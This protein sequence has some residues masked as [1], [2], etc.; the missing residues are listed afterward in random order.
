MDL[1]RAIRQAA[2][3]YVDAVTEGGN[4][5]ISW[6]A[7]QSFHFDGG[8]VH[9]VS[10][11]GIFKPAVL[12][13]PISIRTT[14]PHADGVRPYEDEIS[15]DGFLRYKYRGTDRNHRDNRLLRNAMDA[16]ATLLYF[17]GVAKGLYDVS[18]AAIVEDQPASLLFNV[19]LFPVDSVA[20]GL[21]IDIEAAQRHH[22]L[23]MVKRRANQQG[24]RQSVLRAYRSQ[25]SVCRLR[26]PELLDAAHIVPDSA[27]GLPIVTNGLSM[28][29]IHHAAFDHGIIGVRPDM[30]AEVRLDV[31][32]EVDG[33]M[34]EHGIQAVHGRTL[35]IPSRG[36]WRPNT[37]ALELRYE[38]FRRAG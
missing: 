11:Q 5:P 34:L 27:G 29:K 19:A 26:H 14:P 24:F 9:L 2:F 20:F 6:Q 30:V 4:Q 35:I 36:S 15:D 25:C 22:Y 8:R 31:L 28:C 1:D 10:Q 32:A 12:D 38:E 7:L 23:A 13:L 18:G 33:P 21:G 37:E 3:E 16:G 17:Q